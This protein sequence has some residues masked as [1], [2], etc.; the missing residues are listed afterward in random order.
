MSNT[1]NFIE[2][3]DSE[4][5]IAFDIVKSEFEKIDDKV[6]KNIENMGFMYIIM[7][8]FLLLSFIISWRFTSKFNE[9]SQQM[10]MNG[11]SGKEI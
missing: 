5:K 10:L 1:I 4:K 6:F 11:L 2:Y 9:Y 3:S 8:G 7:I